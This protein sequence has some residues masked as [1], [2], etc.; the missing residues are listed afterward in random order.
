M[1]QN[2]PTRR[3]TSLEASLMAERR[4]VPN[5]SLILFAVLLTVAG[6][7]ASYPVTM[8][9][10]VAAV[11][12]AAVW[13]IKPWLDRILPSAIS[14]I[15][16]AVVLFVIFAGFV[17]GVY[18][19]T[20]QVVQAFSRHWNEMQT[21]FQSLAD[22]ADRFGMQIDYAGIT[23]RMVSFGQSLVSDAYTALVYLGFIAILVILGLPEVSAARRKLHQVVDNR[24]NRAIA[25]AID[26]I[27]GK[28][29]SYLGVT[30]VTSL[31]T[32]LAS[33]LW[34]L[35]VGLDL[36]LAWGI[37]N[38]L[39][40]YIPVIG[41]IVGI[42]PPTLYAVMQFKD[43]TMPIIVFVGYAALQIGISNFVYPLLQGRSLSLSPLVIVLTL[44]LW[45]WVWGIAGALI[46]VPLTAALAIICDHF[47][48]TKWIA[49]LLSAPP[50][51]P[52]DRPSDR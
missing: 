36:A 46:A 10:A 21:M 4:D 26:E 29:R 45:S 32:G 12:I 37:L 27:A 3:P 31:L 25:Q 52:T 35:A 15:G 11:V 44:A 39:L 40:N 49:T 19:A 20:S 9:A 5:R 22:W 28:I 24:D 41:N 7:R 23:D 43:L 30:T 38:F 33:G 47:P 1:A 42:V 13:P 18:F 17:A 2:A 50:D 6:L 51:P 34:A 14:Y 8:P 48:T 16:I